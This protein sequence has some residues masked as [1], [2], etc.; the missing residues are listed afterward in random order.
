MDKFNT[1]R[2]AE[3]LTAYAIERQHS[4]ERHQREGNLTWMEQRRFWTDANGEAG[5]R[6]ARP[7]ADGTLRP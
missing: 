6:A 2:V 7:S 5:R 3:G 1:V 4:W